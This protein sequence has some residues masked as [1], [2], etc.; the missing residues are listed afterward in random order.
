VTEHAVTAAPSV[1]VVPARR[2]LVTAEETN[3]RLGHENLGFLSESHG[4]MPRRPPLLSLPPSRR[5]WDDMATRLPDMFRSLTLRESL[6]RMPVLGAGPDDLDERD[7]LR[8]SAIFSIFAHAYYYV[9]PD[10][11]PVMPDSV[12][13]PWGQI[14]ERLQRPAPHLSFVDLNLYNWRLIDPSRADSVRVDNL[15]LLIPILGNEDERR[16]QMAT[17]E[18]VAELTPVVAAA[19]RAQEAVVAGSAGDLRRELAAIMG[20]LEHVALE[21]FAQVDPNPRSHLHVDPVV[22]GK[23]VAPLATPYQDDP[24]PGPSGTAIPAF[25]LLDSLFGRDR[26]A[27]S[28]GTETARVRAWFP[29]HWQDFLEAFGAISIPRYVAASGDRALRG[30]F[31]ECREA[32]AG[33]AGLLG[34][35]RLKT[36]GFLDLS[37]KAGRSKTLAGFAG[38]FNDRPWDRM[39]TE[40]S[41]SRLERYPVTTQSCHQVR[42]ARVRALRSDEQAWVG[43]VT[44]DVAGSGI[45]YRPGSRCA[46][47]PENSDDLVALTLS[48]L[49]AR[50]DEPIRLNGPWREAVELRHGYENARILALRTLLRFGRIRPVTRPVAKALLA[51][52][53]SERLRRIVEARS[54]EQWELWELLEMLRGTGF[55]AARLWKAHAGEREGICRIVPPESFRMFSVSSAVEGP[56]GEGARE[57]NLTIGRLR[58]DTS[59]TELAPAGAHV[60]TASGFL[61]RPAGCDSTSRRVSVRVV[62]PPN[63]GLPADVGRPVVMFAGGTG[64]SPFVGMILERAR[65]PGAGENWLFLAGRTA[66][67]V[68]HGDLLRAMAG[69][70]NLRIAL[71][72]DEASGSRRHIGDEMLEEANARRL[73]QLLRSEGDGGLGASFYVCGRTGFASAVTDAIKA[74]LVR[75]GDG[76]TEERRAAADQALFGLI[77]EKRYM[78]EVFTTYAG[79][80]VKSCHSYDASE[81]AGHND[82]AKGLWMTIGGR[83]YD[84]GEFAD[85]HPGGPKIVRSYAGMDATDAYRRVRHDVNPEVDAML[86][87][88]EIGVVRRLDF[89]AV[90]GTAISPGGLRFIT[91]KDA[92]RAWIGLLFSAV[93]MENALTMDYGVRDEPV[94]YDERRAI[95]GSPYKTRLCLHTHER[96]VD[97]HLPTLTGDRL[98]DVWAMTSGLVSD[99]HH[100][101]WMADQ[102]ATLEDGP[103]AQVA[104]A[105]AHEIARRLRTAAGRPGPSGDASLRWCEDRA[106]LLEREDR[107]LLGELKSALIDGVR[108]FEHWED[109]TISHG[110]QELL[111]TARALPALIG[112]YWGRCALVGE[113]RPPGGSG[114]P[115]CETLVP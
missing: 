102:I 21:T 41:A 22:W 104:T 47:L 68:H 10:P 33:D 28:I 32:Y 83:V 48:A 65:Q 18:I 61:S 3:D 110:G 60:G 62:Q 91:L 59:P 113:S 89:G 56:P 51:V 45:R 25:Q 81:V 112:D 75:F 44:L 109:R 6:D 64:V 20:H 87:M 9:D 17:V 92:Y 72:R 26:H 86:P 7:L 90:W 50:G 14:T 63:F 76:S 12:L 98:G 115:G 114:T 94:T 67:D 103:R 53:H 70:L 2:V 96:F 57:L 88:Y 66:A 107:R 108:V 55:K 29:R 106:R 73:W 82:V 37:F 16:F 52:S 43:E 79:G 36:Y 13:R 99:R 8:A 111:A 27:T 15:E 69:T 11:P 54:E 93:E 58:Y 24:P 4:F 101:R 105:F 19:V 49:H 31:S 78:Q 100:V 35:H 95:S 46:V 71:S 34:R 38:G 40:L 1:P 77:G 97:Q 39:D 5:V 74:I 80:K 85:M 30:L 23:T 42:I 84:V